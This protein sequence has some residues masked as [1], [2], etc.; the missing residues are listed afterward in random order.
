MVCF[1]MEAVITQ[2]VVDVQDNVNETG[3]PYGEPANVNDGV[4]QMP[5]QV[6][7]RNEQVMPEH[8]LVMVSYRERRQIP[9]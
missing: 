3:K 1:F 5:C 2:F 9:C 8:G 7:E 6:T 4:I